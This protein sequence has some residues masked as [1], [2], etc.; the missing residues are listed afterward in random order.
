MNDTPPSASLF[1]RLGG[2]PKLMHLLKYFYADVRQHQEIAPIFAAHIADWPT[3]LEKI[4]D[5]WSGATGG[6]AR[7]SG[8]MPMK[9]V[10]LGLEE[11]HFHAWLGLWSRHCHAHLAPKEAGEL[12]A[13]AETIGQ[14]LRQIV[15]FHSTAG[16]SSEKSR[17]AAIQP[18]QSAGLDS[19][20]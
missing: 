6:Q 17:P 3:H 4:A 18:H 16:P 1:N 5:F 11:R 2:R 10:P 12:I 20:S 19:S 15:T 13:L 7:Y 9:H 14:R 8:P